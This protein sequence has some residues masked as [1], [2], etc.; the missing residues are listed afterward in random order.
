MFSKTA[1][2]AIRS[3]VYITLHRKENT[4]FNSRYLSEKLDIPEQFLAKILQKLSKNHILKS[5]RGISGGFSL[6]KN[7][8]DIYFIDIIKIFDGTD[9][10][11]NCLLGIEIC[12][13]SKENQDKCPFR[14]KL[15]PIQ[16]QLFNIFSTVSIGEYCENLSDYSD[17]ISI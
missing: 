9:V 12:K 14:L 10:F 7:P 6:N 15:D 3:V 8:F 2:Y 1:K 16:K 4:V 17:T 5:F 13:K 11:Y